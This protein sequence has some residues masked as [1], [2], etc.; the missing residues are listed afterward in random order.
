MTHPHL[1]ITMGDPA[2][3]GPEIIVK[4]C[5]KLRARIAAGD[6]RLLIIGSGAALKKAAA[7]SGERLDIPE[8][9]SADREWPNLCFLQ[10][11]VEGEPIEAGMLSADGVATEDISHLV[12]HS[13]TRCAWRATSI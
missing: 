8:V 7:H 1:A 4:A 10:A 9:C 5:E 11:D 6:L 12:G 13:R 3:V 2:G